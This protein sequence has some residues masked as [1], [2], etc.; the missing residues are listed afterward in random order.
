MTDP[1]D[2]EPDEPQEYTSAPPEVDHTQDTD[3]D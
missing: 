2:N 1:K 3:D